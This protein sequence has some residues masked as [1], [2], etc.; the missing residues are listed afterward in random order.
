MAS[1][2][3]NQSEVLSCWHRNVFDSALLAELEGEK[4]PC[5]DC[6]YT[7]SLRRE[8]SYASK[9]RSTGRSCDRNTGTCKVFHLK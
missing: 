6:I 3:A 2:Q 7:C 1:D 9:D 5:R 4:L 8:F